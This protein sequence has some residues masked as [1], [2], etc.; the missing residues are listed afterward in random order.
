MYFAQSHVVPK[1]PAST[2]PLQTFGRRIRALRAVRGMTQEDLA[3]RCGLF[4]TYMSRIET[5]QANPTLLIIHALAVCLDV[6]IV[7]LFAE[8]ALAVAAEPPGGVIAPHPERPSRGR[9]R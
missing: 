6:P 1:S 5:G 2:S 4:R 3:A 7:Q 8:D 9:V